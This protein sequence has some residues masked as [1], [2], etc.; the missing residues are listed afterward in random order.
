MCRNSLKLN[1]CDFYEIGQYS[2]YNCQVLCYQYIKWAIITQGIVEGFVQKL[3]HS[4]SLDIIKWWNP[5]IN[6]RHQLLIGYDSK[7]IIVKSIPSSWKIRNIISE[8]VKLAN[9]FDYVGNK[10]FHIARCSKCLFQFWYV[11]YI[12]QTELT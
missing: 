12:D 5:V 2:M 1:R 11:W 7:S 4:V 9:D 8:V 10:P 6:V 3:I